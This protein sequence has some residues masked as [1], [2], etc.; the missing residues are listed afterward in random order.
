VTRRI[1]AGQFGAG[2]GCPVVGEDEGSA[3][4]AYVG[5]DVVGRWVGK[6]VGRRRGRLVGGATG[7]LV[8]ALASGAHPFSIIAFLLHALSILGTL[9]A[10]DT[11]TNTSSARSACA[12]ANRLIDAIT[13]GGEKAGEID[14]D[15]SR[16]GCVRCQH[17][18]EG[19]L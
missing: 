10:G 6:R 1:A 11:S 18:R 3:V 19:R 7:F 15:K 4:R 17:G 8:G 16:R 14:G 9:N 13:G 2:V 12:N 5:F